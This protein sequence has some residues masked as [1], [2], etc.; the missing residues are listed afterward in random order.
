MSIAY[1]PPIIAIKLCFKDAYINNRI[2]LIEAEGL[3]KQNLLAKMPDNCFIS[4]YKNYSKHSF[5]IK[6]A[7]KEELHQDIICRFL[8]FVFFK[9]KEFTITDT[10]R[11]RPDYML[12]FRGIVSNHTLLFSMQ[13][14][15]MNYSQEDYAVDVY[16]PEK[17]TSKGSVYILHDPIS[18]WYKIGKSKNAI[19]R[20]KNIEQSLVSSFYFAS[21][22]HLSI[23]SNSTH[24]KLEADLHRKFK[25]IKASG[26][27]FNLTKKDL[28]EAAAY[29]NENYKLL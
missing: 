28:K 5:V 7:A 26:E 9:I 27:W 19:K 21:I 13:K 8:T 12:Y 24:S 16:Q 18:G 22:F 29:V 20:K 25:R 4:V 1:F 10:I 2:N 23:D 6:L 14:N 17:G 3:I 15:V 11:S